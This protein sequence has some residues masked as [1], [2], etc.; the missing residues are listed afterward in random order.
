ENTIICVLYDN[1]ITVFSDKGNCFSVSTVYNFI[2]NPFFNV[3]G[4]GYRIIFS[5]KIYC[6]LNG[7]EIRCPISRYNYAGSSFWQRSSFSGK[8]P[9]FF[10]YVERLVIY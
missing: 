4:N 5:N 3:N 9:F 8:N 6:S 10:S 7:A 2:I 1:L